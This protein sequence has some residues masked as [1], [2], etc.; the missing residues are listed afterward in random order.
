MLLKNIPH[1]LLPSLPDLT[2]SPPNQPRSPHFAL[3]SSFL[4]LCFHHADYFHHVCCHYHH[5]AK[6]LHQVCYWCFHP[7]CCCSPSST[8][9]LLMA[10]TSLEAFLAPYKYFEYFEIISRLGQAFYQN[11]LT[12]AAPTYILFC[13]LQ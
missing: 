3:S 11:I 9:W 13:T 2:G 12:K 1:H 4:Q 7:I 8:G 5:P 6:C 10:D